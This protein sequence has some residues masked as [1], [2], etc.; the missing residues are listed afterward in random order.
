M[1][2]N[3]EQIMLE[4]QSGREEVVK[5]L[6]QRYKMRVFNF[7]LRYL[8]NRADAEDVTADVFLSLFAKKYTYNPK[9]KF[10]TWLFTITRNR[11]IDQ[12]R[13]CGKFVSTNLKNKDLDSSG[14]WDFPDLEKVAHEALVIKE[15]R[16]YVKE[17][18]ERLAPESR[19]AIVLRQY[20]SLSYQEIS[21][22]LGCSLEK[23]KVLI[24]RA[25]EQLRVDLKSLIKEGE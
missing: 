5:V 2:Q 17:A 11:C 7:T 1:T 23:V 10:S 20:H 22:I 16:E 14:E 15:E 6:Y 24:F 8:G 4:F 18:I 3:D 12:L 21:E 13:K 9:A 25:R 19:E